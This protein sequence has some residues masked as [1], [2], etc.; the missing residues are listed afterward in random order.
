[1]PHVDDA[2]DEEVNGLVVLVVPGVGA[3]YDLDSQAVFG[4]VLSVSGIGRIADVPSFDI[5]IIIFAVAI[6]DAEYDG[7]TI[8]IP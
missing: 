2:V 5:L 4:D 6:L 1:M 7:I 8:I 3:L